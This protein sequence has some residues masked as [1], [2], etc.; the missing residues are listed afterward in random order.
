MPAIRSD[1]LTGFLILQALCAASAGNV[2]FIITSGPQSHMYGMRK[3]AV[4]AASRQ[5]DVLVG[6]T[7]APFWLPVI[8]S[9]FR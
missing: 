2:L 6:F 7:A 5:H 9:R 1:L 8:F 3:I 4:E